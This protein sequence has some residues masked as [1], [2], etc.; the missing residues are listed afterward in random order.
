MLPHVTV[1]ALL[2]TE[3]QPP[4]DGEPFEQLMQPSASPETASRGSR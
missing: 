1:T 4:A 2:A 3:A